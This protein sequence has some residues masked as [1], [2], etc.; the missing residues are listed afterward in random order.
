MATGT[1]MDIEDAN[2]GASEKK[3]VYKELRQNP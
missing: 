2:I 3:S 1:N